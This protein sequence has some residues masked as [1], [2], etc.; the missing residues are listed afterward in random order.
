MVIPA[1]ERRKMS[2]QHHET[3]IPD[4]RLEISGYKAQMQELMALPSAVSVA[5]ND[6]DEEL[7]HDTFE[8]QESP[9]EFDYSIN[10]W[11]RKS[12]SIKATPI[13][14]VMRPNG[15]T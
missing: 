8:D 14:Q 12:G 9:V 15:F 2:E 6:A 11:H 3:A 4:L 5:S 1:Q 13:G 10:G 7:V